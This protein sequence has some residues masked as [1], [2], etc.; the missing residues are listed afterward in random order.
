[1]NV[2][3]TRSHVADLSFSLFDRSVH[4]ELFR[5]CASAE[6]GFAEYSAQLQI[7]EAGH[8]VSLRHAGQ[9]ITEVV[10]TR[11]PPLP[12][13]KRVL[14]RRIRES[15][16]EEHVFEN[17]VRYQACFQLERLDPEVFQNLHDELTI[18]CSRAD[19]ACQFPPGHR[20][21]PAPLSLIRTDASA[22]CLLI[23]A[24][25]TFPESAAVVKSQSLFEL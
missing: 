9:T 1:M 23:H 17:G 7:C 22:G 8:L 6:F 18:D 20:L 2:S 10:S 16:D 12:A 19:L 5:I 13:F 3:S 4:P 21:A 25:H 14:E 11:D 15:R 24:F